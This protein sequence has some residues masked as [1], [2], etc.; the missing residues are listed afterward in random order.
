MI[1]TGIALLAVPFVLF[2]Y[3]YI[4]YP[5]LLWLA[6]RFRRES[7]PIADPAEWPSRSF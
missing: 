5:A 6:S 7:A 4:A 1:V 2:G 3:A